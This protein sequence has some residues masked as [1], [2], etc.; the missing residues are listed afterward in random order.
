MLRR[1][2]HGF[3]AI[4]QVAM[5]EC[6]VGMLKKTVVC[7][8]CIGSWNSHCLLKWSLPL[9]KTDFNSGR[10]RIYLQ[11]MEPTLK[12]QTHCLKITTLIICKHISVQY[13]SQSV[14]ALGHFQAQKQEFILSG[15]TLWKKKLK[16]LS[17]DL[18]RGSHVQRWTPLLIIKLLSMFKIMINWY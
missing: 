8:S 12:F 14:W 5:S 10:C 18:V 1:P 4:P 15:F 2:F 11:W 16:W 7:C 3:I 9:W 6:G 17:K 13:S